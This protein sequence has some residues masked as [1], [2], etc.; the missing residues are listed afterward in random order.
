MNEYKLLET[1]L[2]TISYEYMHQQKNRVP[3]RNKGIYTT[4]T[5]L[6]FKMHLGVNANIM[7]YILHAYFNII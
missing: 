3:I 5:R 2:E 1:Y 7:S 4:N 6:V